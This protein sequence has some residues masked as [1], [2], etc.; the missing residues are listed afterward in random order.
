MLVRTLS[1]SNVRPALPA[2]GLHSL[3]S[4]SLSARPSL[5]RLLSLP[6]RGTQTG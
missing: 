5:L 3:T 2:P 6:V 4:P 1:S